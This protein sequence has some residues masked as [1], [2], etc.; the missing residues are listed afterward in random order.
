MLVEDSSAEKTAIEILPKKG[1]KKGI[2]K[3]SF[4]RHLGEIA[5]S[6]S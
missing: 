5:A 4:N 1:F 6:Y 2:F 3:R